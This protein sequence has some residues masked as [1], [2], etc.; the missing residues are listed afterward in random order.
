MPPGSGQALRIPRGAK[1]AESAATPGEYGKMSHL[2]E[3]QLVFHYYGEEGET[4]GAERHLDECEECRELYGSL[5]RVL[6]VVGSRP[7]PE[8]GAGNGEELWRRIEA[9]PPSRRGRE[10]RGG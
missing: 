6:N 1:I 7:A 10:A 5:Q 9:K 4:L 2:T 8:G 3:E